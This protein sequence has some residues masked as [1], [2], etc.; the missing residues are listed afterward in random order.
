MSVRRGL[1]FNSAL[2]ACLDAAL[3]AEEYR[4]LMAEGASWS[5]DDAVA[6]ALRLECRNTIIAPASVSL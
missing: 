5:L 4:R 3:P 6:A 2:T 1:I